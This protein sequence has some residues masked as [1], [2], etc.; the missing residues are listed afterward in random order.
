MVASL[1]DRRHNFAR[2][3]CYESFGKATKRKGKESTIKSIMPGSAG[4]SARDVGN[5][6]EGYRQAYKE[7]A[8]SL[9]VGWNFKYCV[10]ERGITPKV[11]ALW[12]IKFEN[13]R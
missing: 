13:F 10:G 8:V 6:E 7:K 12:L 1:Q 3:F 4:S 11:L 9:C 5:A 2:S